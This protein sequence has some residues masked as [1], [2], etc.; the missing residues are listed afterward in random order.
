MSLAGR[1]SYYR[2]PGKN[3]DIDRFLQ[4]NQFLISVGPDEAKVTLGYDFTRQST[5]LY[6]SMLL[7][8]KD[9]DIKFDKTV[10]NDPMSLSD[11]RKEKAFVT[12]M[13]NLKYKVFPAT[14]P[15]FDRARDLYPQLIPAN[16]DEDIELD[17]EDEMLQQELW[18]NPMNPLNQIKQNQDLMRD[19][20]M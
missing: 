10:I 11:E 6:Y 8:S 19:N 12:R 9:M 15:N 1:E 13:R 17:S 14:N 7:G 5:H 4:E 18:N 2:G 3:T 20:R 16:G